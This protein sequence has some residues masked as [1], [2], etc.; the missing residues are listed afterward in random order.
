MT[1]K[2]PYPD[3]PN[4]YEGYSLRDRQVKR[5]F[6][7][8]GRT[9][10][11]FI[12]N[13]TNNIQNDK[14]NEWLFNEEKG[15]IVYDSGGPDGGLM[16]NLIIQDPS[17][18]SWGTDGPGDEYLELSA[19]AR[20]LDDG[21]SPLKI[22]TAVVDNSGFSI[23]V[24]FTPDDL[25]LTGPARLATLAP[26]T[27]PSDATNH[28]FMIGQQE[29]KL[30]GRCRNNTND[31]AGNPPAIGGDLVQDV[32]THAVFTVSADVDDPTQVEL[33]LYL[34][35]Q[36]AGDPVTHNMND[37]DVHNFP[38][39][40][41]WRLAV[42]NSTKTE[43]P[44]TGKIYSIRT[45]GRAL[46]PEEVEVAYSVGS[47]A[48]GLVPQPKA[49]ITT[50]D[51][52]DNCMVGSWKVNVNLDSVRTKA[53]DVGFDVSS[54]SLVSG[55]DYTVKPADL[56]LTFAPA[57]FNKDIEITLLDPSAFTDLSTITLTLTSVESPGVLGTDTVFNLSADDARTLPVD[58]GFSVS[59]VDLY[60]IDGY[61][62]DIYIVTTSAD[63]YYY[64][65]LY[66][67]VDL[68]ANPS[69]TGTYTLSGNI[70]GSSV[71][72]VIPAGSRSGH[73]IV[74]AAQGAFIDNDSLSL[75]SGEPS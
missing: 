3:G 15:I 5:N 65:D 25:T 9:N 41:G 72:A 55:V 54:P 2:N 32:K 39:T 21:D 8:E 27:N 60:G 26:L 51:I 64:K 52:S 18:V 22:Y 40:N 37:G 57:K 24:W 16:N 23:E 71:S 46:T 70:T 43:R 35:G 42:G 47:N 50:A 59:S 56:S 4:Y 68:S 49:N 62:K 38:W 31:S 36:P 19:G 1:A 67:P 45:Y 74:S 29:N 12:N 30:H 20:L 58:E 11:S 7:R 75:S 17:L 69:N 10:S 73:L 61:K 48:I 63:N 34:S 53:L 28:D 6:Q 66:I 44:F 33:Q 14:V 13:D